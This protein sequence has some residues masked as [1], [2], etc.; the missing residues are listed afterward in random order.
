MVYETKSSKDLRGHPLKNCLFEI[1]ALGFSEPG[2]REVGF[3]FKVEVCLIK[4]C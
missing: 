4:N 3:F 1:A 2:E